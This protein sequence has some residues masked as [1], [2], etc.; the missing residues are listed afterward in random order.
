MISASA[1][2]F[3]EWRAVARRL[4]AREVKPDEV[5][6]SR[7]SGS[8]FEGLVDPGNVSTAAVP[9]EFVELARTVALHRDEDRWPLLYRVLYRLTRGERNLLKIE[10]DDDMRR[11]RLMEKAVDA[12]C[13]R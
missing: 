2:D 12:I 10:V 6:W 11:L 4:L 8:L 13:T 3:E 1:T 5:V 7:E 9:K